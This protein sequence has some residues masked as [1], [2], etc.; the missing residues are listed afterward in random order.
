MVR[1]VML[2]FC[3]AGGFG[4]V[5]RSKSPFTAIVRENGG[6][7]TVAPSIWSHNRPFSSGCCCTNAC[8]TSMS[9]KSVGP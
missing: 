9:G 8:G 1:I 4:F 6:S 3:G 2:I 7:S 5:A